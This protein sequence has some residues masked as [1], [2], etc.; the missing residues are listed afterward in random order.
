MTRYAPS[1]DLAQ[2]GKMRE[3]LFGRFLWSTT[4][5]NIQNELTQMVLDK[6]WPIA[7]SSKY[8]PAV[9]DNAVLIIGMLDKTYAASVCFQSRSKPLLTSYS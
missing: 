6:M 7:P 3:D 9:R 1:N 2:L 8:H 5:E 4:D